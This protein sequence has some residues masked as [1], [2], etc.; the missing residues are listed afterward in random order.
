MFSLMKAFFR[1]LFKVIIKSSFIIRVIVE[2][3]HI[4]Q[5]GKNG[6][7]EGRLGAFC[8]DHSSPLVYERCSG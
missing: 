7:F 8:F 3:R 6:P 5:S 4:A 2:M 1:S